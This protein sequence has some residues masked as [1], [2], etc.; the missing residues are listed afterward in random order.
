ME[1]EPGGRV[2]GAQDERRHPVP[3]GSSAWQESWSFE[4]WAADGSLGAFA[5]LTLS[6]AEGVCW[7][8]VAVVGTGRPLV[9]L[10][11][12]EVPLPPGRPLAVRASGLWS[13]L[14]CE[15]P[16][17][18]WSVGLEAFGVAYDDPTEAWRSERGD[19]TALGF[20]VE[21]ET[22]EPAQLGGLGADCAVGGS[23]TDGAGG[24]HQAC[25]VHGELLVGAERLVVDGPGHR[26]HQWGPSDWSAAQSAASGRLDDSTTFGARPAE[27]TFDA[28]GLPVSAV[29]QLDGG[30]RV[31]GA[32]VA[33]AP[34]LV[35]VPG[36]GSSRL[37]RALFRYEADG[38]YEED[39]GGTGFGWA[40]WLRA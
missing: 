16:L 17:E 34:V 22:T 20:D 5:R 37:A 15:S 36:G 9:A 26:A 27:G 10:R 8:W 31:S 23:G 14:V 21:W 30:R 12:H 6:P 24:Y 3:P 2:Y 28:R 18:H 7:Y 25:A 1:E 32:P 13:D 38:L 39:G 40:E 4:L 35:P 11:D 33:H 29:I 19:V